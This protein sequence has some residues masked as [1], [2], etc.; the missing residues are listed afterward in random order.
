MMTFGNTPVS[1]VILLLSKDSDF[2]ERS[3]LKGYPPKVI[4]IR[5][6]NCSSR[7][8]EMILRGHAE[9]IKQFSINNDLAFLILL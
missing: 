2:H 8:I 4:W 7:Q 9:D 6:G 5:R 3:I 1:M